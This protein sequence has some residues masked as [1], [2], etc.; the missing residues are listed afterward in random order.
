MH[1]LDSNFSGSDT[2][3][4]MP[5][6]PHPLFLPPFWQRFRYLDSEEGGDFQISHDA[7]QL[8]NHF[9][10]YASC[11]RRFRQRIL[12]GVSL[13]RSS[14]EVSLK[15][16]LCFYMLLSLKEMFHCSIDFVF[17]LLSTSLCFTVLPCK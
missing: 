15:D 13:R 16:R 9:M 3:C 7:L 6:R 14:I 4:L 10:P 5:T 17:S 8:L 11:F 2:W 12:L 1:S